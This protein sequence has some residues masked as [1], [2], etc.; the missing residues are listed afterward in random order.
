MHPAKPCPRVVQRWPNPH[1][2]AE[3][4]QRQAPLSTSHRATAPAE[5]RQLSSPLQRQ[6]D[7]SV[8]SARE[9]ASQPKPGGHRAPHAPQFSV[10]VTVSLHP[11]VQHVIP[12]SGQ[13][14]PPLHAH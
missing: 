8:L 6:D 13:P 12:A 11:S 2:A 1:G 10:S 3:S 9:T 4:P 14:A 7:W 5:A